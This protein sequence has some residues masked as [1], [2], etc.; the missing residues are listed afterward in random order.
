MEW[1]GAVIGWQAS[2][3]LFERHRLSGT[4]NSKDVG[5]LYSSTYSALVYRLDKSTSEYKH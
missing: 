1:G 2:P 4:S 3:T 5:C